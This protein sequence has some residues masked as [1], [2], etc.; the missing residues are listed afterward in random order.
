MRLIQVTLL[1]TATPV[2]KKGVQPSNSL[3]F[4]TLVIQN[5]AAHVVRVGDSTVSASKGI[6]LAAGS[7]TTTSPLIVSPGL[8][9]TSDTY[10]WYLFGTIGDLIDVL[11]LD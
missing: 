10:E 2:V 7:T 9:Y 1:A 5:N 3:P 6:A 8:E 4:Q 11:L